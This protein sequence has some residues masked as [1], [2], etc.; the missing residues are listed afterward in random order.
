[1]TVW[2]MRNGESSQFVRMLQLQIFQ[3]TKVYYP[4]RVKLLVTSPAG[5]R[6]GW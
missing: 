2:V 4:Q 5:P 6:S 1:M 3:T